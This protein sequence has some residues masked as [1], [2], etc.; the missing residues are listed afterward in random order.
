MATSEVPTPIKSD[1]AF[2]PAD[3][4]SRGDPSAT[5][6]LL[7]ARLQGWKR[8]CVYL[9]EYISAVAKAEQSAA[10]D[11]EKVLKTV[12]GTLKES[13]HFETA[14][15]GVAGLFENI[16][17]NTQAQSTLHAET[18]KSLTSSVLPILERLHQELK[19]KSKE[20]TSGSGK[21]AKS[22]DAARATTQKHIDALS[23]HTASFDSRGGGKISAQ[24]DPYV[25]HRG[26]YHRLNKQI[27]EE[28][29]IRKDIVNVQNSFA[30]FEARVVSTFQNAISAYNQFMSGQADREK[31]M[32]GDIAATSS[33]IPLDFEW[34]GFVKRNPDV[35]VNP[36]AP[37]R[38][39]ELVSF[40]NQNHRSTQALIEGSLE[41]KSRGLGMGYKSAYY[42]VTP[43]GFLHQFKDNDNIN[44]DPVP[45]MSLYLPDCV[46]GAV[47]GAKFAVKGKDSSGSKLGNKMSVSSEWQ[48]K[49]HTSS[50]AAKW[51][52]I[53]ASQT[54]AATATA[55]AISSLPTSPINAASNVAPI[56]GVQQQ[57]AVSTEGATTTTAAGA[58]S[59]AAAAAG[60]GASSPYGQKNY[61]T[62]PA[63]NELAEREYV[64]KQ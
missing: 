24:N 42:V 21:G 12:S 64:S 28:N 32:Y 5:I 46:V 7:D 25:L 40:P 59:A 4:G 33:A 16:R 8:A 55:G 26:T 39:L 54:N 56:T 58:Q 15:G 14:L 10:K 62:A 2:N 49:A 53:I 60:G 3:D 11:Q 36:N 9:E 61:H 37:P 48:F 30:E 23:Q 38:K 34:T 18:S 43:A 45:D 47:D 44:N 22:V 57:G 35:L 19:A 63:Q 13:H 17:A 50:E 52:D 6:A 31:A 20:V 41:R 27:L 29:N 1:A 51:H